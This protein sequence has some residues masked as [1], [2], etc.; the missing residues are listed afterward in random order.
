MVSEGLGTVVRE[1][2][3]MAKKCKKGFRRQGNKCIKIVKRVSKG[4]I[5]K[6]NKNVRWLGIGTAIFLALFFVISP[7]ASRA[8][9]INL[10]FLGIGLFIYSLREFQDDLI[11]IK[12]FFSLNSLIA[13]GFGLLLG[14]VFLVLTFFIPFLSLG[15]PRLPSSIGDNIQFIFV[16]IFAPIVETIF[17]QSGIFAFFRNFN[18]KR[19]FLWI[20]I[21]S[22]L[23]S[24][25]HLAA[26]IFGF[27]T[28]DLAQ[29]ATAFLSNLS[30]FITA[31][32][33]SF[34]AML[35]A[36]RKGVAKANLLFIIVFHMFLNAT[37]L[38]LAVVTFVYILPFISQ[39]LSLII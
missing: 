37:A 32:L 21:M 34:V 6:V 36:L 24:L 35:F 23:F 19:K 29:G 3:R 2:E 13:V 30:S 9:I 14:G 17:F 20:I 10:I 18:P 33:F 1:N 22:L 26:F 16:V 27:Y 5:T 31:F 12:K 39:F 28:L 4:V 8:I 15:F 7:D 38:T 25:F 11:G